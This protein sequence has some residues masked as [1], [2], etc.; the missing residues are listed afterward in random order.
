MDLHVYRSPDITVRLT[1]AGMCAL[2]VG[3]AVSRFAYTPVLPQMLAQHAVSHA[4]GAVLASSNLL[5]YLIGA[6]IA[7]MRIFRRSAVRTLQWAL[8]VNV[9]V[10]AAMC[11]PSAY[12]LWMVAR[13]ISGISS[14]FIFVYAS[15][16]VLALRKPAAATALFS[17]V[18]IGIAVSGLLIP[19]VYR[20]F[21]S[22]I[23]GWA[24]CTIFAATLSVLAVRMIDGPVPDGTGNR[25]E[26]HSSRSSGAP[27]AFWFASAAY[28]IAGFS[29]VI[30]ATFLVAILAAQPALR[31]IA[32]ISWVVV[33]AVA[34]ISVTAWTAL[35]VRF[36]RWAMLIAALL[37]LA[38]G[39]A[40][41]AIAVNA[42]GALGGAFGLG[43][44]FMGISML[45]VAIVRD[46]DPA[47]SSARIA[48]A[49]LIFS[50]GQV[51]GPL[52]AA[53]SYAHTGS[54]AQALLTA[55]AC[56]LF[57]GVVA[58]IGS[59]KTLRVRVRAR[60]I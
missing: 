50:V 37:L 38:F 59:R 7:G 47:C 51:A 2:I 40:A 27:E 56:L 33:G 58:A 48:Q 52:F 25:P 32:P 19:A 26:A 1:L 45:T 3:M 15:T 31:A 55:A 14:A 44:S 41:P 21:P 13:C 10:L 43:A 54:Y 12:P 57:A 9:L 36:G 11:I 6:W 29:Y 30:P 24:A 16:L 49:T 53:Y 18:G 46:L 34:A 39:C 23:A 8:A 22:W 20:A 5:G 35:E 42:L 28:G 4:Q 60:S 17:S